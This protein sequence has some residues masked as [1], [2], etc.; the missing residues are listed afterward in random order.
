MK[1]GQ[2]ENKEIMIMEGEERQEERPQGE[3]MANGR[4]EKDGGRKE[5]Q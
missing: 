2:K 3:K 5:R 1:K 4:N